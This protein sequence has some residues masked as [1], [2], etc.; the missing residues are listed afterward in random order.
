MVNDYAAITHLY[1]NLTDS[2][3]K[4]LSTR[5]E[6]RSTASE[7]R[8]R[9]SQLLN[10]ME[11]LTEN[12]GLLTP[13]LTKTG[14]GINADCRLAEESLSTLMTA[15]RVQHATS[16][17]EASDDRHR[18]QDFFSSYGVDDN[19]APVDPVRQS[20]APSAFPAPPANPTSTI[21]KKN[22]PAQQPPQRQ[23]QQQPPTREPSPL[24][25]AKARLL[26]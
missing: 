2:V 21:P 7:L 6:V 12:L 16:E 23:Q 13:I 22:P 17:L 20:L 10:S 26:P 8:D 3:K 14:K 9:L 19:S 1:G 24:P 11:N 25:G 18:I 15:S 4:G 5:S